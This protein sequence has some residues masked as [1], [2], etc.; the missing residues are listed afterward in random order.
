M[1]EVI[2]IS[3]HDLEG[4]RRAS[5]TKAQA[6]AFDDE[7][8]D[9]I[10]YGEKQP[11][12][13]PANL[14]TQGLEFTRRFVAAH[15][16]GNAQSMTDAAKD[17][18]KEK[19]PLSVGCCID[20]SQVFWIIVPQYPCP[21]VKFDLQPFGPLLEEV[22]TVALHAKDKALQKSAGDS[23]YHWYEHHGYYE[24]ARRILARLIEMARI[25][26]DR[27]NE[28]LYLNNFAFEY[29]LEKKWEAGCPPL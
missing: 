11:G 25:D 28:A 8:L 23:L 20:L 3:L 7:S 22:W 4:R 5:D 27:N 12:P 9:A 18:A 13:T 14:Y 19:I 29:L 26:G 15:H 16:R 6:L 17:F 10:L 24:E 21:V 1:N 2:L